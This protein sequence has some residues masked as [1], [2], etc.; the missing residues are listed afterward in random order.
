MLPFKRHHIRLLTNNFKTCFRFYRD[1]LELPV[2]YGTEDADYAEFKTDAIHIALYKKNL[3]T[4]VVDNS[5][6][7]S[8]IPLADQIAIVIR[9]DNVDQVYETIRSKGVNFET[10]PKDQ[11]E[12]E[13]RT[14]HF[15][16]P[17]GILLE[18]NS[19]LS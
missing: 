6:G 12:W 19:D 18:L 11:K 15:R 13:C 14:A 3:M 4:Q 16:D 7:A 10:A 5:H 17:D 2:R 9:V 1:V 8:S